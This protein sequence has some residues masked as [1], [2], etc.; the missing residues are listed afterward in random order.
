MPQ[1][2]AMHLRNDTRFRTNLANG[3]YTALADTLDTLNY[4]TSATW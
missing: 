3:N 2:A 4:V 1:T